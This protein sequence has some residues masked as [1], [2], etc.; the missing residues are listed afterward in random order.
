MSDPSRHDFTAK[1]AQRI[2]HLFFF[3]FCLSQVFQLASG[4]YKMLLSSIKR[5]LLLLV[6]RKDATQGETKKGQVLEI[7]SGCVRDPCPLS[8]LLFAC[9]DGAFH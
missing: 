8:W 3:F 9:L 6:I 2:L 4:I 5:E 7:L 1:L